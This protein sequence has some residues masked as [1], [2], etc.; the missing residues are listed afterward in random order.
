MRSKIVTVVAAGVLGLSGLA[1][2]GPALAA[3]GATEAAAAVTSRVDRVTSALAG[4]VTEGTL[5]QQQADAVATTLGSANLGRGPGRPGGHH[6]PGGGGRHLS[7]AATALGM[8]AADLRTALAG[9]QTLAQVAQDEG[10]AVEVLVDALVEAEKARVARAVTD[11][12]LT[13][14]EA[15]ERLADVTER[16]TERVNT[17][18]PAR[19]QH[20]HGDTAARTPAPAPSSEAPSS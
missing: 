13:Q 14:A 7:A 5:T 3:N 6:G 11:G 2:A 10:V 18:R 17:A 16:V 19:L 9:G 1:V 20:R 4:L 15:D 8:T 12:R